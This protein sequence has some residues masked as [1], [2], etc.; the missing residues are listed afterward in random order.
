[1]GNVSTLKPLKPADVG[2]MVCDGEVISHPTVDDTAG[3]TKLVASPA[4]GRLEVEIQNL[5]ASDSIWV[6]D[7]TG[8]TFGH[9]GAGKG[10]LIGP[11][12]TKCLTCDESLDY[13]AI[14]DAGKSVDVVVVERTQA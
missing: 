14:A 7:G 2:N 4:A 9:G 5:S 10:F 3:G 12:T 1:M 11:C 6:K 8:V 13:Y